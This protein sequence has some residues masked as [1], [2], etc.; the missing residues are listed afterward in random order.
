MA[1]APENL[2]EPCTILS[3]FISQRFNVVDG[4]V[5]A[6]CYELG[7]V[8]SEM[9]NENI[10]F[11]D[12]EE[13]AIQFFMRC[14]DDADGLPGSGTVC[15]HLSSIWAHRELLKDYFTRNSTNE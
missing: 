5:R 10:D 9:E 13:R 1:H 7:K 8:L 15:D 3:N 12:D 2:D 6:L 11:E 14:Y 4:I